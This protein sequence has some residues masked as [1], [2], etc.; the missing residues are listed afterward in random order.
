MGGAAASTEPPL[1]LN[2][3]MIEQFSATSRRSQ[4]RVIRHTTHY[5]VLSERAVII[6][7]ASEMLGFSEAPAPR[8]APSSAHLRLAGSMATREGR[9]TA[10]R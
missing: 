1:A 6:F 10:H 5:N 4:K 8:S 2:T 7:S 3:M 9:R